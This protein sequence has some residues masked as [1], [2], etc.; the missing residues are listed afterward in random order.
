MHVRIERQEGCLIVR[1]NRPEKKNALT[2]EMY[3]A[4][5]GALDELDRDAGLRSLVFFGNGDAFT[6]GNDVQDFL[7]NPPGDESSPVVQFL[8]KLAG[9]KKPLLAGVEGGAV[10]IGTTLLLH[11]DLVYAAAGAT[12]QLPFVRMGLVPEAASSL[13]LPR[14]AGHQKASELLLLGD[15]FDAEMAHSLGIVNDVVGADSLEALVLERAGQIAKLPPEA[16][17]QTKKLLKSDVM[18]VSERLGQEIALFSERLTSREA[19][20]AMT[21]F[22]EKRDPDFSQFE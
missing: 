8:Y 13:L 4:M 7:Q 12:F 18:T 21:A 11:C 6:S 9:A 19:R 16:V 2:V 10:G 1:F 15:F 14:L 5:V 20:E 22:M 3:S 17:R